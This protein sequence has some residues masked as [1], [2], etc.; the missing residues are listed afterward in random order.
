MSKERIF[1]KRENVS[2][3]AYKDESENI[4]HCT[5]PMKKHCRFERAEDKIEHY[6]LNQARIVERNDMLNES[7]E[8]KILSWQSRKGS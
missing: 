7:M 8:K 5:H 2:R 4:N 1:R 6:G 3:N